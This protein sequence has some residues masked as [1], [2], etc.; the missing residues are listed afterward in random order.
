M[1]ESKSA[2]SLNVQE[3]PIVGKLV[4]DPASPPDL[5]I[6]TG[7]AGRSTRTDHVRL[8][9]TL[10]FDSFV[11]VKRESVLHSEQ[12]DDATG[13][14]PTVLW[15]KAGTPVMSSSVAPASARLPGTSASDATD[16]AVPRRLVVNRETL[17]NLVFG[18]GYQTFTSN[19]HCTAH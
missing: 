3:H 6:L 18:L 14:A 5:V 11:E 17:G 7:Y 19:W 10:T 9:T 2:N 8:Y 12:S 15:V 16:T 13:L 1:S 4:P